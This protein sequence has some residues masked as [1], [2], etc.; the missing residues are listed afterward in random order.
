MKLNFAKTVSGTAIFFGFALWMVP[1]TILAQNTA[2]AAKET[3]TLSG[4]IASTT[5]NPVP[6]AQV[7]IKNESTGHTFQMETDS[8]GIY[9]A[10][11]IDPGQYTIS[12]SANGFGSTVDHV[13]ITGDKQQTENLVLPATQVQQALPA[14]PKPNATSNLP[15]AP[16]SSAAAPS[17][18]DLGFAPNQTQANPQQ[19]A[20]LNKRTHMLKVHQTLGLITAVPMFATL[21]SGGGAKVRPIRVNGKIVGYPKPSS[22]NLDTHI[23]LGALTSGLYY[24]TAY[25]AIR[26]PKV[27]GVKPTGAI[28][29]HRDLEW[30]HG[31]G[32]ILTP[33]LGIMAYNQ[34]KKGEKVHGLAAAHAPVADVT[35]AA[36]GL[37]IIA[38]SWPIHLKFWR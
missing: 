1:N 37:A 38:V 22:A 29:L 24:T 25:F 13:T 34:E 18:Q 7:S 23:A 5:G 17:L 27:A 10:Q 26:A 28:R 31:P 6:H 36:Y 11:N 15:N 20:L 14:N 35:A 2:P 12:V 32:M 8:A 33:I 19:Q 21:V 4:K 9:T 3:A 16:S 30:V